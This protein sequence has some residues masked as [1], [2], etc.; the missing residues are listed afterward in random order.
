MNIGVVGYSNYFCR[1]YLPYIENNTHLTLA[2]ICDVKSFDEITQLLN[3]SNLTDRP[4]L[5]TSL[6]EMLVDCNLD[7]VIVSTPH[8]LHYQYVKQCLLAKCHVLV[9]KPLSFRTHEAKDL[10]ETAHSLNLKLGVGNNRRYE[11]PYEYIKQ[12]IQEEKFGKIKFV[13][14]LFANSRWY[15]YDQ[16][17]RGDGKLNGGGALI[18]VGHIAVDLLTWIFDCELE[19]QT[20]VSGD[21][22]SPM[23]EETILALSTLKCNDEIPVNLTVTYATPRPSVQEELSIY[24]EN[25]ALFTRRFQLERSSQPPV[26]FEKL[27]TEKAQER[28]FKQYPQPFKPLENLID[29]IQSNDESI[30]SGHSNLRI[31]SFIEQVYSQLNYEMYTT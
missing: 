16:I 26:V 6:E 10:I 14:Y 22:H 4:K 13:N 23:V 18:D 20:V 19:L 12:Q 25:G 21:T 24:G 28:I 9:D 30:S 7:I 2:A 8:H 31:V 5:F 1:A 27:G 17:W 3:K 29:S 11:K 15:N